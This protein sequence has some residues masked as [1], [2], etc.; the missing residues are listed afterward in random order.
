MLPLAKNALGKT[1][2]KND[3]GKMDGSTMLK[4]SR[5]VYIFGTQVELQSLLCLEHFATEWAH[6]RAVLL[7]LAPVARAGKFFSTNATHQAVILP[8][9]RSIAAPF[10]AETAL[11]CPSP[12][13]WQC[14]LAAQLVG[15]FVVD[16]ACTILKKIS[17][18]DSMCLHRCFVPRK[19]A[20]RT[21]TW[22]HSLSSHW[23]G[24]A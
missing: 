23:M 21:D 16:H 2:Q 18:K 8:D 13:K 10:M 5:N 7:V 6:W 14:T 4:L 22:M 15:F 20:R 9:A 24:R 12:E 1:N 19:S 3:V 17:S 11:S